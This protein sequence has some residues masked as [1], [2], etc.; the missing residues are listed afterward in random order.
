AGP[1]ADDAGAAG[2]RLPVLPVR[3]RVRLLRGRRARRGAGPGAELPGLRAGSLPAAIG[4]PTARGGPAAGG[5][6]A[7]VRAALAGEG[8]AVLGGQQHP[9]NRRPGRADPVAGTCRRPGPST[10]SVATDGV[11]AGDGAAAARAAA[12]SRDPAMTATRPTTTPERTP[13]RTA[14]RPV[15]REDP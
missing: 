4:V 2:R 8:G 10:Q 5:A 14:E 11:L 12:P 3:R 1:G 6:G 7:G 15:A 9:R 13:G